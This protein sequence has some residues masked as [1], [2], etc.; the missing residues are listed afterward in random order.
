[1]KTE[2]IHSKRIIF[3][4]DQFQMEI[5]SDQDSQ[6][7]RYFVREN[8]GTDHQNPLYKNRITGTTTAE[9]LTQINNTLNSY[10]NGQKTNH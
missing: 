5:E 9:E 6:N 4:T 10:L 7:I 1:M 8:I 3:T 2:I